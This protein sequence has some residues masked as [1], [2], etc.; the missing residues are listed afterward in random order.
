MSSV[1]AIPTKRGFAA[2][3][4]VAVSLSRPRRSSSAAVVPPTSRLSVESAYDDV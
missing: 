1:R 3:A 2:T 4:L